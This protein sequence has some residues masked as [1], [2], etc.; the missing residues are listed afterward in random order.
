M[1]HGSM[2]A[3]EMPRPTAAGQEMWVASLKVPL[4]GPEGAI[5]GTLGAYMDI[6]DR[7]EAED[8]LRQYTAEVEDLYNNVPCGYH[9]LDKNGVFVRINDT[10]LEWL[11][12]T[13]EELIGKK[14]FLDIATPESQQVFKEN[15]PKPRA[16]GPLNDLELGFI[17]KDGRVLPGLLNATACF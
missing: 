4:R 2:L 16:S 3:A 6:T 9:S 5:I 1:Q 7:K 11:G 15:F 8:R 12:Y 17:R 13:R 14:T 10:E